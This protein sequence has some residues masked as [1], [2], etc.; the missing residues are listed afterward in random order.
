[1][2]TPDTVMRRFL[3]CLPIATPL[4]LLAAANPA[5][6]VQDCEL[7][8]KP[9]NISNGNLTAGKTGLVRCKDRDSGAL[10]REE[11]LQNGVFMGL[12]RNYDANGKLVAEIHLNAKGNRQGVAREFSPEG[13]LLREGNYDNGKETGLMRAFHPNGKLQHVIYYDPQSHRPLAEAEFNPGGQ[14]TELR[15]GNKPLLAPH[16]DD[17]AWCG[18]GGKPAQVD[19]FDARGTLRTRQTWLAGQRLRTENFYD[20]GKPSL[21]Y[22][23]EG[24]QGTEQ[25]W[26]ADGVKRY[27]ARFVLGEHNATARVSEQEFSDQGGL[28]RETR[29]NPAGELLGED[30]YYLNGQPRGKTAY[31][32][33]PSRRIAE[34][35]EFY[36]NGQ[37]ARQG[38]FL[39]ATSGHGT[40]TPVGTHQ[41]F[42]DNGQLIGETYYDERGRITRERAWTPDGSLLRDDEVFADGSRKVYAK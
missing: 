32:G 22:A 31:S 41:S 37:R 2:P 26:S 4:V 15:C 21:L 1:M 25:R 6:A 17:A 34:V 23:I 8:G 3:L 10:R 19:L 39:A 9:I 38:H 30:R 5:Y 36:D 12:L 33:E 35:T 16:A 29:W 7:D 13:T 14:L 40:G 11:E 27:E 24:K 42:S 18:F 28:V 20:N